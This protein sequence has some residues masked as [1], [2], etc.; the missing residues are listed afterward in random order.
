MATLRNLAKLLA[1]DHYLLVVTLIVLFTAMSFFLIPCRQDPNYQE[2][3]NRLIPP[4]KDSSYLL[5]TDHL[6]RDVLSNLIAG[7]RVTFE[8]SSIVVICSF[9]IGTG[10]GICSGYY[11]GILD[12]IL[13]RIVD[14]QL[15][16]PTF[17]VALSGAALIGRDFWK[18]VALLIFTGWTS[19]A[20]VARAATLAIRGMAYTEAA[21][22]VGASSMRIMLRYILPNIAGATLIMAFVHAPMVM[23]T[24]ASLSFLGFG[25]PE[26]VPSIGKMVSTGYPYLLR[27]DWWMS[28]LPGAVLFWIVMVINLF[29]SAIRDQLD[30]RLV[31]IPKQ[32]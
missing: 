4:F 22:S 13:M 10:L 5:G 20:R 12:S 18:L 1:K 28:L 30:P 14:L 32:R 26:K 2:L 15:S 19:Y 31:G 7:A 25:L 6:G 29:T 27:G 8:I 16:L 3:R 21:K 17:L 23:M 24:E 11:G 9:M